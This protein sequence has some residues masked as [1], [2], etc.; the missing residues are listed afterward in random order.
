MEDILEKANRNKQRE[1]LFNKKLSDYSGVFQMEQ[2][3]HNFYNLWRIINY[4][5]TQK[6]IWINRKWEEVDAQEAERFV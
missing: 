1:G 5:K 3:F 4:W 2:Y 6:D